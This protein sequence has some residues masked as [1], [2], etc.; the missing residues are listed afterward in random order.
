MYMER[1]TRTGNGGV[2]VY[3]TVYVHVSPSSL[4]TSFQFIL[5]SFVVLDTL[6]RGACNKRREDTVSVCVCVSECVCCG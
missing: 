3:Y 4:C 5:F 1:G 2:T 6:A